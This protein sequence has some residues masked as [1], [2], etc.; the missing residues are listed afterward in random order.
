[1]RKTAFP[2]DKTRQLLEPGPI[3]LVSAAVG[4]ERNIMTMGWHMMLEYTLVGC[5]LWDQNHTRSLIEKSGE[6]VINIPTAPL[7]EKAVA[8]GNLH[9]SPAGPDKFELFGLTAGKGKQV[10]VPL[11]K[12]CYANIECRLVDRHLI[13]QYSLFVFEVLHVH[14]DE[15]V[16]L[17]ETFH[18]LGDGKFRLM[19]SQLKDYKDRFQPDRLE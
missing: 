3:V 9:G 10:K 19:G 14:I 13:R 7:L 2:I 5:F 15:A 16:A 6:C 11:I 1:M 18:Y 4:N 8:I 17:P 12:E